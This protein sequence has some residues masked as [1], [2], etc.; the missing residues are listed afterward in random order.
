MLVSCLV[1]ASMLTSTTV[2]GAEPAD[3]NSFALRVLEL[4]NAE[5]QSAGLTP[6]TLNSQLTD[7]AQTYS[8]VL[9]S[10]GCFDHTCGPVPNFA[11]RDGQ[12]GY[13]GWSN[14]G[15]NIAGGYSTPEAV[16]AGWMASPGHRENILSPEFTEIGIGIASGSGQFGTYWTQE[17]GT[18]D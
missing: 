13:T 9:A 7:S 14:L 6:L 11:D 3:S 17:F 8:Q 4:T 10:S 12:A 2:A 16:V 5:R 18:R 15:E 1:L